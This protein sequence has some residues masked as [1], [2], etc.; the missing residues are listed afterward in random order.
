MT[1]RMVAL[2]LV[3]VVAGVDLRVSSV[4]PHAG[5]GHFAGVSYTGTISGG[6]TVDFLVSDDGADVFNFH[7][8]A[9]IVV[10]PIGEQIL[11]SL[12]P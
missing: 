9:P 2:A 3:I 7:F 1:G 4:A 5:A 10:C 11:T 12:Y 8:T 6:G